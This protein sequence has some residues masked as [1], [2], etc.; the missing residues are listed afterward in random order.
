MKTLVTVASL[1]AMVASLSACQEDIGPYHNN[2]LQLVTGYTA[3][4]VCSC[5]F[6]IGQTEEFCRNWTRASPEVASFRIDRENKRVESG[7]VMLWGARARYVD[8]KRGCVLE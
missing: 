6:V 5:I 1:V 8:E 3:K 7:A 4:E 2:D